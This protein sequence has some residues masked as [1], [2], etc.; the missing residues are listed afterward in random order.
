M[1]S[2]RLLVLSACACLSLVTAGCASNEA[3]PSS[4]ILETR[5][6]LKTEKDQV[7]VVDPQAKVASR[8]N[9]IEVVD[10]RTTTVDDRM[11]I[12]VLLKNNRGRRDVINVRMRWLDSAG[13]VAAQYD[14]WE[15]IALEGME[16]KAVTLNAPTARAEDFRIEMQAND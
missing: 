7:R 4:Q 3:K 16:E 15:T 10:I 9:K 8:V 13:L 11:R 14:A 12:T 5:E 2:S 1:I 6:N